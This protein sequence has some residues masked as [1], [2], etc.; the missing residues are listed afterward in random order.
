MTT[1]IKALKDNKHSGKD[2]FNAAISK[3]VQGVR[4]YNEGVVNSNN[5]VKEPIETL[6]QKMKILNEQVSNLNTINVAAG[7]IDA[8]VKAVNQ[9][10][11]ECIQKNTGYAYDFIKNVSHAKKHVDDLSDHL[12]QKVN[13]VKDI[14]VDERKRLYEIHK[15]QKDDL[16]AVTDKVSSTLDN[17][18]KQ[19]NKRIRDDITALI[20]QLQ[21]LVQSIRSKLE[22]INNL[23]KQ[24]ESQL[25][26]WIN[27]ADK[28]VKKASED[29][30]SIVDKKPGEDE[31]KRLKEIATAIKQWGEDTLWNYI[32]GVKKS[33]GS[34]AQEA[35]RRLK[36][37]D[38]A[39]KNKLWEIKTAVEGV[40][41]A[42]QALGGTFDSSV[43]DGE[44]KN[45][46][47]IMNKIKDG[48][49]KI[50]GQGGTDKG[51]E[52]FVGH[53]TKTYAANFK[54]MQFSGVVQ[55]W[56][57]EILN[58]NEAVKVCLNEYFDLNQGNLN[59]EYKTG[60]VVN[61]DNLNKKIASHITKQLNTGV[62]DQVHIQFDNESVHENV[63]RVITGI[64]LFA[65]K[66][67]DKME[68]E[69]I[70]QVA[71]SISKVIKKNGNQD[72][73][74]FETPPTHD[75]Y[76]LTLAVQR[77]LIALISAAKQFAEELKAFTGLKNG[78]I[79][80]ENSEIKKVYDALK[81]AK[82]LREEIYNALGL[83]AGGGGSG[84]VKPNLAQAVDTAIKSV[85]T[86]V[87]HIT[88]PE[89]AVTLGSN[90]ISTKRNE[91]YNPLNTAIQGVESYSGDALS[92][93][94]TKE[95]LTK[96]SKA[97]TG[98]AEYLM[99]K[100]S[101]RGQQIKKELDKLKNKIGKTDG[102]ENAQLNTLQRIH[103]E[104]GKLIKGE[105]ADAIKMATE[106]ETQASEASRK[107]IEALE[108]HVRDTLDAAKSTITTDV[109][110]R[111]VKFIKSLL[112]R[113]AEKVEK[114]IGTLPKDITKDADKGFK[115]FMGVLEQKL[116]DSQLPTN[117]DG[118]AKLETLSSRAKTFFTDLPKTLMKR[119]NIMPPDKLS[120]LSR[121]LNTVFTDLTKYNTKFVND[122]SALNTL[123]T[124]MHPQSYANQN[125]PLLQFLKG[126][127]TDMHGELDKAYV[128]VYDSEIITI[129]N[130]ITKSITS[131]GT[132]CAKIVLTIVPT[133]YHTLT[134]LRR[135]LHESDGKWNSYNIYDSKESHHSLHRLFFNDNGYDTG[136]AGKVEHGELNHKSGFT[137][138]NILTKLDDTTHNLF[139]TNK[140]SLKASAIAPTSDDIP[141]EYTGENGVIPSLY[142]YL[143]KYFNVC[144]YTH[145]KSPRIPCSVYEMLLWVCG[146][147]FSPV[148]K[149]LLDH[150]NELFMVPIDGDP[151][152]KTLKPIDAS[153]STISASDICTTI[154]EICFKSYPVLTTI[155]GHGDA[156]TTYACEFSTNSL[157]FKYPTRGEE[158]FQ[159]LLDILRK[160]FPPLRFL[161]GQCS[162]PASEHGWLKCQ[163]GRDITTVNQP[164]KAHS[165]D[166]ANG[167]STSKPMC[168]PNGHPNDQPTCQPRS[169]LMSYLNDTLPG[170]LPH[171][172]NSVG[173]KSVCKSCPGS[174]PGMPCL[175]PLGFREFSG[176]IKTGKD[177]CDILGDLFETNNISAV[178]CLSPKP[179]STL[180]EHFGF[181][182]YLVKG[183]LHSSQ[184]KKATMNK[185]TLQASFESSITNTSIKLFE[186]AD[187][188]TNAL[189]NA[190]G[191]DSVRHSE[192][193]HP[194]LMNLTITDFCNSN[195]KG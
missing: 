3:V 52:A 77:I 89:D 138:Q 85:E 139:V 106:F 118:N 161:F 5:A 57:K 83:Q 80:A 9:Q 103:A 39:Y 16:T 185:F 91:A 153:P 129:Y 184:S 41:K 180:P 25:Q 135:E 154:E 157:K 149:P 101:H 115:G 26:E 124:E 84:G 105:V 61:Y 49:D 121:T 47:D 108:Q 8:A 167:Q 133:V 113:F 4:E 86:Q 87:E 144:H 7:G 181:A 164:C 34:L 123:L 141:F 65:N 150:V 75:T 97:I 169:P 131:D 166:K 67:N 38:N 14:L 159:L 189:A 146:L 160:L 165:T 128:S 194:H 30:Q 117:L 79:T 119:S 56:I 29:T 178:F 36:E 163:Y 35:T 70:E 31:K 32:D 60:N 173:C 15:T 195:I 10:V 51:L 98:N 156:Y 127:I 58:D 99:D 172:L 53:V 71:Q 48:V 151:S 92:V 13:N 112:T 88:G 190:Y 122:L 19:I 132:K 21:K 170:H 20:G 93:D 182:L 62:I 78:D 18:R 1:A 73:Y 66:L 33:L 187:R 37:L 155:A 183:W 175:T 94:K 192:C 143:K 191:S 55:R 109:K 42:V 96:W 147:Q 179:P 177:I 12:K 28:I 59:K 158:C 148:F 74:V 43:R 102:D 137:G 95:E 136:L 46:V 23:L 11:E 116:T 125:N 100:V 17:A 176:S 162:N 69:T 54:N 110:S 45:V 188:F 90:S 40:P 6:M 76:E 152:K 126:G 64:E 107:T 174:T 171:Q 81:A 114:E 134:Q 24:Y 193:Q 63:K 2:G 168:Q 120:L 111:Y 130:D 140:Q 50:K 82:T 142:D 145:I 72:D 68:H 186:N 104:L 27:E 22:E 44:T